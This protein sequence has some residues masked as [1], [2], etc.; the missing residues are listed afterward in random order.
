MYLA[1]CQYKVVG[2]SMQTIAAYSRYPWSFFN[3]EYSSFSSLPM[4]SISIFGICDTIGFLK[5]IRAFIELS[6]AASAIFCDKFSTSGMNV[7]KHMVLYKAKVQ[8][9]SLYG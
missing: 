5:L 8:P 9:L 7:K 6:T 4:P 3:V 2:N 1:L